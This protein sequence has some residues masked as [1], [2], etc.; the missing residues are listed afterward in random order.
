MLGERRHIRGIVDE[1]MSNAIK[2][3]ATQIDIRISQS[4][5][6]IQI[7][8]SDNGVGMDDKQLYTVKERLNRGRRDEMEEYYGFLAGESMVGTGLGLVGIQT[9]R[10]EVTSA[11]NQGTKITV[12]RTHK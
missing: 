7:S 10:A 3:K 6:E 2:A 4:D 11:P 9:D 5:E 1:L 12:Y 8:V